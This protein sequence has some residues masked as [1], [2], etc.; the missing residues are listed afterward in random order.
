MTYQ[1]IEIL[2]N[3]KVI[4]K[5][6]MNPKLL[7]VKIAQSKSE[8]LLITQEESN[9]LIENLDIICDDELMYL[10]NIINSDFFNPAYSIQE[11]ATKFINELDVETIINCFDRLILEK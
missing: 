2:E 7:S 10:G 3:L 11:N 8:C 5:E 9:L 6:L 4:Y 1:S